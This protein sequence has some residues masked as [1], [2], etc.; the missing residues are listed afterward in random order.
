MVGDDG[1]R[2]GRARD[3]ASGRLDAPG[4][5]CV[6]TLDAE[7]TVVAAPVPPATPAVPLPVRA[8]FTG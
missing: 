7:I 2:S 4:L 8:R 3:R 1:A 5:E 6:G